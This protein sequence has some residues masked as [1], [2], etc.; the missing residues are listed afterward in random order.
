VAIVVIALVRFAHTGIKDTFTTV[1]AI[2]A[3]AAAIVLPR[4][5]VPQTEIIVLAGA[6]G[7]GL[8]WYGR[9]NIQHSTSNIEHPTQKTNGAPLVIAPMLGTSSL[10]SAPMLKMALFFLKVGA[11]LFGSGYVLASF[12]RSGLVEQYGWLSERELLDA[13]AVGQITPGPLLT[14]ATFIGYVL[15]AQK[16]GG[17]VSG[18]LVGGT[19]ATLAIFLPSFLF[20]AALGPMLN[21]IRQNPRA[22]GA[23]DAMNAAVVSLIAVVTFWLA[24]TSMF[25]GGHID[26]IAAGVFIASLAVLGLTKT[27]ATWMILAAAGVGI[28]R[29]VF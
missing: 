9:Q 28:M 6:A 3:L 27:N 2:V 14:T 18:G 19:L 26:W 22:R 10:L 29:S 13:I 25:G 4:L 11:T 16:F 21:R 15:G 17:S 12:L 1:V 8:A 7:A 5:G 20:I 23:L 24:R